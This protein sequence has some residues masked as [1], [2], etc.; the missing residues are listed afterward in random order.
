VNGRGGFGVPRGWAHGRVDEEAR[1]L[2]C[3]SCRRI[4]GTW[5]VAQT[6]LSTNHKRKGNCAILTSSFQYLLKHT[7]RLYLY[8][9]YNSN[10]ATYFP[11]H[12]P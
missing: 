9:R 1:G 7:A 11:E 12:I 6:S 3:C 2:V 10:S 8:T 5:A 4:R